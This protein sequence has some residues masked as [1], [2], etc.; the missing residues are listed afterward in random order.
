[1]TQHSHNCKCCDCT[2]HNSCPTIKNPHWITV[3]PQKINEIVIGPIDPLPEN[4]LYEI[5]ELFSSQFTIV[6]KYVYPNF[7]T[8]LITIPVV[9]KS[10]IILKPTEPLASLCIIN[11][12]D[13]I[14][15]IKGKALICK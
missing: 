13:V 5:K 9:S 15:D 8:K 12:H 3:M 4:C 10:P 6:A 1:M 2:E 11:L 7:I 14:E